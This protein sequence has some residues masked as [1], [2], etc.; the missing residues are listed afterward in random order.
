MP[1]RRRPKA[2]KRKYIKRRTGA[3]AQSKQ[4]ASLSK[5]IHNLRKS[6]YE[7]IVTCWNRPLATIDQVVSTV[8]AYILPIPVS[9][10]NCY[11]QNT[12]Q[13]IV[14][15]DDQ[16]LPWTDN[17]NLATY[18]Q[19][20]FKKSPVFGSSSS[21]RDSPEIKHMGSY[22]KYRMVTSEPSFSTY[23]IFLIQPKKGFSNQL[24]EDR[25]LRHVSTGAGGVANIPG[26]ASVLHE[27]T[28]YVTHPNLLGTVI[29]KKFWKVHYQREV[30]FS[31]PLADRLSTKA[32]GS[33]PD[34][35]NNSLICTGSIKIPGGTVIKNFNKLPQEASGTPAL[36][37][38][39]SSA[40]QIGWL[41]EPM[42]SSCYLVIINNGATG[43]APVGEGQKVDLATICTDYYKAVV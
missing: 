38:M 31:A 14:N 36:G 2:Q 40:S 37:D 41:D 18:A 10:M 7:T 43:D 33:T 26:S 27:G 4:I 32:G 22:L 11:S 6:Q 16:R 13:T 25:E 23:S 3:K 1:Y 35:R 15:P 42:H 24:I 34:S 9:M 28:D 12:V 30:N 5:S 19:T 20:G 21:A 8:N 29:N 39:K 17:R